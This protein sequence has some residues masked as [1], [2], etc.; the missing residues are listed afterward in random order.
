MEEKSNS[1]KIALK[2]EFSAFLISPENCVFAMHFFTAMVVFADFSH[3]VILL[4]SFCNLNSI[5]VICLT[6]FCSDS[7]YGIMVLFFVDLMNV[8]Q[9]RVCWGFLE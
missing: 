7:M 2:S 5:H 1:K 6:I 9:C 4:N 3:I 8:Q